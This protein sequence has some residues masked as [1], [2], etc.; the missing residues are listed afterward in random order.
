LANFFLDRNLI[1]AGHRVYRRD[2]DME[3]VANIATHTIS[4]K[5]NK[6]QLTE[7]DVLQK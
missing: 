1:I 7:I 3:V 6:R 2:R 4:V 5:N